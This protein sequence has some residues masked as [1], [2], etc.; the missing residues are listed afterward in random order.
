M[1]GTTVFLGIGG[2]VAA[3]IGLMFFF[4]VVALRRVVPV[5]EVHIVQTRKNTVSYGKGFSSTAP[6]PSPG[7]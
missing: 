4:W 1:F 6:T 2:L 3:V 7:T 5:N